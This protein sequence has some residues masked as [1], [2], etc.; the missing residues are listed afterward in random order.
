MVV[1]NRLTNDARVKKEMAA[2]AD[3]GWHV[4]VIAAP[5]P[6][7][8]ES[9]ETRGIRII[10]PPFRSGKAAK[11]REDVHRA[12]H[13]HDNSLRA[14]IIR[15]LR[16]NR[17]RR[18]IADLMLD[19]PWEMKL[20]KAAVDSCADVYH[21]NDLDTLEIC[22]FAAA[23]NKAKLI[24]D[25]HE[26]W[27]ESSRF[28]IATGPLAKIRLRNIEKKHA[29]SADAVI[30]VTPLRGKKMQ[31]MYPEIKRMEIVENAP[32]KIVELPEQGRLRAMINADSKTV[33]ALYQGVICP[34]R[35]LE[36]LLEAAALVKSENIR[37]VVIGM[38]AW[39]GTLQRKAESMKLADRVTILPPVASEELPDITVDADM[40]FILFRN[41][42]L[43]H[44]Y[45]LPN[46]LYEYMMAGVPIVSSN[47]PELRRVIEEVH[48]GITVDPEN[49]GGIAAAVEKLAADPELRRRMADSGRKN[50]MNR[51][52]WEPQK[53]KLINL[54]E[55][56]A[57]L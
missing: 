34:E 57:K 46:K 11:L 47:F 30:S 6:G 43:N 31:E 38:D 27:L 40:G 13:R 48:C 55:E 39:N 17:L 21:A 53:N 26:L 16:R 4:T 28:H 12:S 22:A 23:K 1:K 42:C 25:S 45:S 54:Y 14:R 51:Y 3:N 9:E 56:V 5:E 24:Y 44:Y 19:I 50:A 52:N 36:E 8:P 33:I 2:L 29:G 20:R 7:A 15:G 10:R 41:T 35:G 32:E 18:C 37:F 49:P